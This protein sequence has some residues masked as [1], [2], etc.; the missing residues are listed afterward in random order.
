[1][2]SVLLRKKNYFFEL[3]YY[4]FRDMKAIFFLLQNSGKIRHLNTL[5]SLR[6]EKVGS[7]LLVRPFHEQ[8]DV[9]FHFVCIYD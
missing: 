7:K 6:N 1:M 5:I 9:L 8:E 3:N 2:K 4:S